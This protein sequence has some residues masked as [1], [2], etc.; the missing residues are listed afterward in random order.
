L[1]PG[2]LEIH[3][4][5]VRLAQVLGNL[6]DNASKYTPDG[7]QIG[8][9][10]VVAGDTVVITVSDTGIGISA[11]ALPHIFDAFVQESHAVGYNGAGLGIGLSVVRELIGA[12]G[13]TVVATSAGIGLGSQFVVSLPR[14]RGGE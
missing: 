7:G 11:A 14:S 12:Q 10:L 5:P 13:G 2:P 6:L 3:G 8:L 9:A 1:P 4:D